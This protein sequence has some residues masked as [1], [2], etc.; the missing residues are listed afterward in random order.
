[1]AGAEG[2]E[3]HIN[4]YMLKTLICNQCSK[5]F[6]QTRSGQKRKYC[7]QECFKLSKSKK[8]YQCFNCGKDTVNPKFCCKS[9]SAKYNNKKRGPRSDETKKKISN[10]LKVRNPNNIKSSIKLLK[11]H[12]N[13]KCNDICGLYSKVYKNICFKT[14]LIFYSKVYQ[15]YHPSVYTNKQHYS[16]Q[17]KFRFSISQYPLW[18]DG[19][20][21]EKHGWY[22]TPGSR[23]GIKNL[24]G[25]SRDHKI[26]ISYGFEHDIDP[27]IISHPANCE[28]VLHKDN[29]HKNTKC[30][31]TLDLLMIRIKKFEELYPNWREWQDLNSLRTF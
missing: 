17:C 21:I 1:M 30:S 23:K 12:K 14:G 13:Q 31:I 6:T 29:Q 10:K 26:S 16:Y 24:N 9:C 15:K 18:F 22:S 27:K 5:N 11:E 19:T 20:L 28:L 4:T 3:P 25:V 8:I 2:L 7:S